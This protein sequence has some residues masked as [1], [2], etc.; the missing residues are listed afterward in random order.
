MASTVFSISVFL[1]GIL[2][3]SRRVFYL[4]YRCMLEFC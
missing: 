1:A 2:S 4:S 3:F